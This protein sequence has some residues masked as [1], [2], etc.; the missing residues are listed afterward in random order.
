MLVHEFLQRSADKFPDCPAVWC[1]G[2][3]Q[4]FAHIDAISNRVANYLVEQGIQKGDRVAILFEN[5]LDYIYA[6]YGILKAGGVTVSLNT[7]LTERDLK[8]YLQNSGAKALIFQKKFSSLVEKIL[9]EIL[10][11]R[12]FLSDSDKDLLHFNKKDCVFRS[13]KKIYT[14]YNSNLPNIR[15]IDIDLASIIYT[16][17]STGKPKGVTLT[18]LNIVKNT[19]SI[20]EYLHLTHNDRIMVVL[21]FFY[22]YGK[23]LLNT[24]FSVG[25]SVVIDNRFVFPNAILKTMKETE[26]TGF[27]GVPSTFSILLNNSSVK[28]YRFEKLRYVTQAGGAMAPKLQKEVALTFYPAKLYIMYGATEASAR[29]SYL[30]PHDLPRKWGSIGKAIPN[31]ELF[32]ADEQGQ[33]LLPNKIGEIVARGSNIM[34]GYWNDSKETQRVL[35]NGLYYTGDLGKMDEEGFLFVVGR[36]N[37][38]IKVGANRISAK[39]IEERILEDDRI[40]E[41]AVI[42]VPDEILGEAIKAFIVPKAQNG[43]L[44]PSEV[45][46]FCKKSLPSFKVPKYVEMVGTLPKNAS[47]K[48][49]KN[50]LKK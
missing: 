13:L 6:Y 26:C 7:E 14:E 8:Y 4:N 33:P 44:T 17:G 41:T 1:K 21:P 25:G 29:L 30:N 45:I 40:L 38:M 15:I 48:I 16:S 19:Q 24:H 47:G 32:V 18:H 23:S 36:K 46:E 5:S 39:E 9:N 49:L 34:Q 50:K 12:V 31:V 37:D 2:E 43:K 22:V 11:V 42:G 10:L 27:S 20:V 28:K 3:W 35:R